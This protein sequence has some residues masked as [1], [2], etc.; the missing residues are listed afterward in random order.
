MGRLPV[1]VTL[2]SGVLCLSLVAALVIGIPPAD[3]SGTGAGDPA[4]G[5]GS[6]L[7]TATNT[8]PKY[9]PTFTGKGQLGV[10]VPSRR[11]GV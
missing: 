5:T 11:S 4:A 8:G 3:G 9:A 10:R 6:F 7:L 1:G 2:G